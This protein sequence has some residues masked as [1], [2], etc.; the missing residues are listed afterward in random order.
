MIVYLLVMSIASPMSLESQSTA[1][2]QV[3]ISSKL[4]VRV[5]SIFRTH[6]RATPSSSAVLQQRLVVKS[7][8]ATQTQRPHTLL[9]APG[10]RILVAAQSS[11][12]FYIP[13]ISR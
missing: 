4:Q 9:Q 2:A 11:S 5:P 7:H 13:I 12:I 3:F 8:T 6:H 1:V 10:S